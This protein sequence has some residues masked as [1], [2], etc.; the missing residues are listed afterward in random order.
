VFILV[1]LGGIFS[2]VFI[3]DDLA[4]ILWGESGAIAGDFVDVFIPEGVR[5][6]NTARRGEENRARRERS[7]ENAG[8][9]CG[10]HAHFYH[11]DNRMS[12]CIYW[13][14]FE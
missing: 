10:S 9:C 6:G 5:G 8:D 7:A 3:L 12:M 14:V 4:D 1:E 13:M 11:K 2:D